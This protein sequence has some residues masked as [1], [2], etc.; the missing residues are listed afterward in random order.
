[1]TPSNSGPPKEWL[2]HLHN[3]G[4]WER[5]E[6]VA[7]ECLAADPVDAHGHFHCAWA[8]LKLERAR[9]MQPHVE[10]L[11]GKD[12]ENAE[13]LK[14]AALWHMDGEGRFKQARKCLD[15]ALKIAPEEASLWCIAAVADLRRYRFESAK[16]LISRA[17]QLDPDDANIA[18]LYI[19]LHSVEQTGARAAWKAVREHE[20]ALKLD[21]ESDV[22]IASMGDVFLDDLEMP[23]R[24]EE[25]YRRALAIDPMDRRHQKRLWRAM[26]ARNV[27]FRTLR[28]PI[29]GLTMVHNFLRG[30]RIKPWTA[31]FLIIGI[32]FVLAFIAWLIAATV[33]FGPPALMV[34]WLVLA[35]IQLASRTA[36]KVGGWWLRFHHLPF[37]AR[38][39]CCLVLIVVFWWGL[40]VLLGIPP[41]PGFS[42]VAT[43]F[44]VHLVIMAIRIGLRKSSA[45]AA[46][47]RPPP[48][49]K[50]AAMPPPLPPAS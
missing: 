24:A 26:Q 38:L 22:L 41:A 15:A 27:W 47:R 8:L 45:H 43:F 23:E 50:S 19:T 4:Q 42:A 20:D 10:F 46:L 37:A 3:A 36:E 1:M 48:L 31:V 49:P 39:S 28:L 33:V 5:L 25:L 13:Y 11:L 32:K 18:H 16:Q 17:R 21:P 12:P 30:L 6:R 7:R 9:E 35:D 14:L 40:F 34:E 44:V 29:S 2:W